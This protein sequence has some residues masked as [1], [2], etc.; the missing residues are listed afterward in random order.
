VR[1]RVIQL[2]RELGQKADRDHQ[3]PEIEEAIETSVGETETQ[4]SRLE[5][6]LDSTSAELTSLEEQVNELQERTEEGFENYEDI[7]EYLTDTVEEME[8]KINTLGAASMALRETLESIS[9]A[10]GRRKATENLQ[11]E[12]NQK[13]IRTASC[14][15]CDESV[16]IALL[17]EPSCPHCGQQFSGVEQKSGFFGS[18]TLL[19][20]E[21]PALESA[22]DEQTDPLDELD[23]EDFT[24]MTDGERSKPG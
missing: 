2:K 14:L 21:P 6:Q 3:H 17:V 5:E 8:G 11:Q 22:P 20:G 13:G 16:D 19:T 23:D 9:G 18:H 7:L 1:D 12:A 4:V 10:E 15:A 24:F